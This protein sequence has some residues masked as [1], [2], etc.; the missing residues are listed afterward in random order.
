MLELITTIGDI[1][2]N[3]CLHKA[4]GHDCTKEVIE[5]IINYGADVNAV[6]KDN[7]TALMEACNK[8]KIDV[9][10]GLLDARANPNIADANGCTCLHHA[11]GGDCSKDVLQIIINHGTDVNATTKGKETALMKACKK[12][13]IN[14]VNVLLNAGADTSIVD[15]HSDTCLHKL[16]QKD[17]DQETLHLLLDHGAP[18]NVPNR[19]HQT[20][21]M[22]A[23]DQGNIDAMCAL[24]NAGSDRNITCEDGNVSCYYT[25]SGCSSNVTLHIVKQ[26]L[27]PI[28]HYLDLPALE[29]TESLSFNLVSFIINNIARRVI[30]SKR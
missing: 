17:C 11:A 10:N 4:V 5:E 3:T 9:I 30:C 2:G 19:S 22:L 6:N 28:W 13:N 27:N 16:L 1:D 23:Y 18:V 29:V 25:D 15:A 8:G 14:V 12:G 26:W 20:A 21:Y 24:L 7:E